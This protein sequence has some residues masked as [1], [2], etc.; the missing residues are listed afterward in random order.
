MRLF[1]SIN[2]PESFNREIEQIQKPLRGVVRGTFIDPD[3]F[4]VTLLF[5]GDVV[6]DEV[7]NL[8]KAAEVLAGGTPPFILES[9]GIEFMGG[10]LTVAFKTN[11][12]FS[13]ISAGL[14]K[15]LP[16]AVNV[17]AQVPHLTLLRV[18]NIKDE[19]TIQYLIDNAGQGLILPVSSFFLVQSTLTSKGPLYNNLFEFRLNKIYNAT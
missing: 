5:L 2:P 1:F 8:K 13:K 14:S 7:S 4:H 3:R 16:G 6:E 11:E 19:N 18:K 17:R 15:A 10:S 9:R 12:A